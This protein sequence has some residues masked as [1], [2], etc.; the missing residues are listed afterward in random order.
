MTTTDHESA[1]RWV[2]ARCARHEPETHTALALDTATP[3]LAVTWFRCPDRDCGEWT[4]THA[5]TGLALG[6]IHDDPM[7]LLELAGRLGVIT[8]SMLTDPIPTAELQ[9][10]AKQVVAEAMTPA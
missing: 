5:T 7:V 4:L 8:D 3:G 6:P 9:T 10:A 2:E 1:Y